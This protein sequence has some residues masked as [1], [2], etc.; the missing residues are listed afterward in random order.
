MLMT[1]A[2]DRGDRLADGDVDLFPLL[3]ATVIH[4]P[5]AAPTCRDGNPGHVAGHGPIAA[6][7]VVT[8]TLCAAPEAGAVFEVGDR[9]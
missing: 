2:V 7:R 1:H 6:G 5:A 8:L 4:E 3:A 9:L